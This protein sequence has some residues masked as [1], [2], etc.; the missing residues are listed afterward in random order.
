MRLAVVA[1]VVL[2]VLSVMTIVVGLVLLW[3]AGRVMRRFEES[4]EDRYER[5]VWKRARR[6]RLRR[7]VTFGLL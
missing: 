6:V 7:A 2:M 1:V 5:E 3:Y 4:S